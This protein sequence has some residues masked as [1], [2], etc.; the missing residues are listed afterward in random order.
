[1]YNWDGGKRLYDMKNDPLEADN[2]YDANSGEVKDLWA[3][4]E[5]RVR[6]FE[7]LIDDCSPEWVGP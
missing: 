6:A 3:L 4:L 1:M 2:I 7:P 5:P